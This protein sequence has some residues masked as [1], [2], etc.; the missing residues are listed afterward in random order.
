MKKPLPSQIIIYEVR[1]LPDCIEIVSRPGSD[2]SI[3]GE[4]LRLHRVFSRRYRNRRIGELLKE[5]HLT[6]GW[7]TGFRKILNTLERYGS[8]APVWGRSYFFVYGIPIIT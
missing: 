8:P 7:N 5:M 6:E 3:S 2:R 4:R 1:I